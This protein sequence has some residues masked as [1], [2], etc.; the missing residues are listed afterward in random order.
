MSTILVTLVYK[1]LHLQVAAKIIQLESKSHP[2]GGDGWTTSTV[3][4]NI[5]YNF[6]VWMLWHTSPLFLIENLENQT[7]GHLSHCYTPR[8]SVRKIT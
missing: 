6:L 8:T 3:M 4:R 2:C 7:F 1:N 5:S